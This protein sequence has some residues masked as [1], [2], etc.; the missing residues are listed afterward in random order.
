MCIRDSLTFA[1]QVRAAEPWNLL[2]ITMDDLS[3]DSVGAFGCKLA[4]TTPNIDRLAAEGLRFAQAHVQVGNCMP[5]RNVMFS[6]KYPHNNHVE[7]F[8]MVREP[9]YPVLIDFLK[10]AG[11]YTAIRG[12]VSHTTP[13]TRYPAWNAS[14]SSTRMRNGM[15]VWMPSTGKPRSAASRRSMARAREPAVAITFASSAS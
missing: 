5:S 6:G 10:E 14:L 2:V 8:Y 9:G 7:G 13:Y 11:Y 1:A 3:C 15:L 12:K 4:D